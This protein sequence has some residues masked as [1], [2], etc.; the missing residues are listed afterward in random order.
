VLVIGLAGLTAC[1]DAPTSNRVAIPRAPGADL[2]DGSAPGPLAGAPSAAAASDGQT[3]LLR[4]GRL[5]V[6]SGT[7][8]AAASTSRRA[9]AQVSLNQAPPAPMKALVSSTGLVTIDFEGY[10]AS[11]PVTTQYSQYGVTFAGATVLVQ[12]VNLNPPFPPHSGTA[13]VYDV[14]GGGGAI[15]LTFAKPVSSASAFVTGN[16]PIGLTCLDRNGK[17]VGASVLPAANFIGSGTGVSPNYLLAVTGQGIAK[18]TFQG[19][20]SG[21]T[22]TLDDITVDP[23]SAGRVPP[24]PSG[25]SFVANQSFICDEN[26]TRIPFGYFTTGWTRRSECDPQ[27]CPNGYVC[28]NIGMN[29]LTLEPWIDKPIGYEMKVCFYDTDT[30]VNFQPRTVGELWVSKETYFP[31]RDCS[32][33]DGGIGTVVINGIGTQKLVRRVQ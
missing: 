12:N 13:V 28:L 17:L 11:T 18:C 15:S 32:Y 6:V 24:G 29:A 14:V 25:R 10:T 9:A 33:T 21:N 2:V 31:G 7:A 26:G 19:G 4:D 27:F 20:T 8:G 30:E 16:R 23:T 1:S 22:Y 3:L 5:S